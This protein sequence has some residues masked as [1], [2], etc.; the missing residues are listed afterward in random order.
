[1]ITAQLSFGTRLEY[2]RW[3]GKYRLCVSSF[4]Q[5]DGYEDEITERNAWVNCTRDRKLDTIMFIPMLLDRISERVQ[6][7]ISDT[8]KQSA[9]VREYLAQLEIKED[10]Q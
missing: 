8:K 10:G 9:K 5:H 4:V 3:E 6:S 7:V 1:M 2:T